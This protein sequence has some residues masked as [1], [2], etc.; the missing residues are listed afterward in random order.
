MYLFKTTKYE[1]ITLSDNL[2]TERNAEISQ[3]PQLKAIG[4]LDTKKERGLKKILL[5]FFLY[6][7]HRP[8]SSVWVEMEGERNN[9]LEL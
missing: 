2:E 7:L 9:V 1:F 4:D 5:F 3:P 6:H 8:K